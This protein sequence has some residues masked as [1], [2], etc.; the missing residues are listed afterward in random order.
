MFGATRAVDRAVVTVSEGTVAVSDLRRAD[1]L[2]EDA[3]VM[4]KAGE[5]VVIDDVDDARQPAV[6]VRRVNVKTNWP[7]WR[8]YLVFDGTPAEVA[9]EEFNRRNDRKVELPGDRIL[10]AV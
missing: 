10:R 5:Q 3:T 4:G 7:G 9:V 6:A 8:G 2:G 1:E